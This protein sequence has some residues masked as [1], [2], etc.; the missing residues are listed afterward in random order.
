[1]AQDRDA[2]WVLLL[3]QDS[4]ITPG[5]RAAAE[6]AFHD[7][8]N[9]REVAIIAPLRRDQ[10]T[11]EIELTAPNAKNEA[12]LDWTITSGSFVSVRH[13]RQLGPYM[14]ELFSDYVDLE[15]CLRA[16]AHGYVILQASDALLHH[17][18]GKPTRHAFL[19][20]RCQTTNHNAWRRYYIARNRLWLYRM[21]FRVFPKWVGRD[22]YAL[23]REIAKIA[24]FEQYALEKLR[25]IAR[26]LRDGVATSP[27]S[28]CEPVEP[29]NSKRRAVS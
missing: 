3:D 26:G 2:D 21:Y 25:Y 12:L 24:L 17:T 28:S 5:Y 9:S 11:G 16:R 23:L 1:M 22:A 20:W 10:V 29:T 8:P 13:A 4:L 19:G 7:Y 14:N 27:L 15:Y 18:V 6:R